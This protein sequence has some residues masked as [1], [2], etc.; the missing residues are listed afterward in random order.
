MGD[1]CGRTSALGQ[2]SSQVLGTRTEKH[3]VAQWARERPSEASFAGLEEAFRSQEFETPALDEGMF[4]DQA[5]RDF[6]H[7]ELAISAPLEHSS[8]PWGQ[9]F[10]HFQTHRRHMDQLHQQ[11]VDE[12]QA[13]HRQWV[14]DF[15][16]QGPSEWVNQFE[17]QVSSPWVNEFSSFEEK[18]E[19]SSAL[20]PHSLEQLLNSSNPKIRQS[21]FVKFLSRLS[22]KEIELDTE[23]NSIRELIPEAKASYEPWANEYDSLH[24]PDQNMDNWAQEF[25][26]T[27]DS[28]LDQELGNED[29]AR[30]F[31][32]TNDT[33]VTWADEFD[34]ID[35]KE[36]VNALHEAKFGDSPVPDFTHT[37]NF[38][39]NNPY[40]GNAE[41]MEIGLKLM[42]DGNLSEAVLAFEAVVQADS[43]NSEAWKLLGQCNQENES[44]TQAIAALGRA[45]EL[46]PY[47]L[48]GLI[49]L[50][51]SLTNDLEKTKA[52]INLR[53]WL[54]NHPE[55]S[56]LVKPSDGYPVISDVVRDF[57]KAAEIAPNDSDVHTVLGVLYNLSSDYDLAAAAF[58]KAL[59]LKPQA[60]HLWNKLGATLANGNRSEEAVNS[61]SRALSL[62][63]NYVRAMA[64]LGISF[65]NQEMHHQACQAYLASLARNPEAN[66]IWNYLRISLSAQNRPELVELVDLRDAAAFR[67]YFDF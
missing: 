64:N 1:D 48:D 28:Q 16:S 57:L 53:N 62:R 58:R 67:D 6:G 43:Q 13:P 20:N 37:Y 65:A 7:Q 36:Y 24:S 10:D 29:W 39:A 4:A 52:V 5:V 19:S 32:S 47:H 8:H 35:W 9:E 21:R 50:S 31:E 18:K 59:D 54:H 44:D 33:A 15:Q 49:M 56:H 38:A 51:V 41:A 22:R 46:D 42:S 60:A 3:G 45:V 30:E 25:K 61:Y 11:W 23:A 2:L 14:D 63:P 40:I 66:H 27:L 55:Y 17:E 26:Q 34:N 12:F